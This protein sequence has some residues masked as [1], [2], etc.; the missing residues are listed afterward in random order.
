M[1]LKEEHE[2]ISPIRF[3][4]LN[5]AMDSL[6]IKLIY[7]QDV[8]NESKLLENKYGELV[9]ENLLIKDELRAC[10]RERDEL[11]EQMTST[12][13]FQLL[14]KNYE[15]LV[16]ENLLIR[17]KLN[18]YQQ[19]F[20]GRK[21]QVTIIGEDE[22]TESSLGSGSVALDHQQTNDNLL[23]CH[24]KIIALASGGS[25]S[26]PQSEASGGLM[27]AEGIFSRMSPKTVAGPGLTLNEETDGLD[28]KYHGDQGERNFR[29]YFQHRSVSIERKVNFS[30][31]E[32]FGI[33][34]MVRFQE[35]EPLFRMDGYAHVEAVQLFYSNIHHI[36]RSTFSFKTKLYT[37]V[38][39]VTPNTIA[40]LLGI[41]RPKNP[42]RYPPNKTDLEKVDIQELF[43]LNFN[44][45]LR[46]D[47]CP[48][49]NVLACIFVHNLLPRVG[50]LTRISRNVAYLL[51]CM[52]DSKRIDLAKL[53]WCKMVEVFDSRASKS[54]PVLPYGLLITKMA[55]DHEIELPDGHIKER[56][57]I[58]QRTI[59]CMGLE[60]ALATGFSK[61]R[62][63]KGEKIK[64]CDMKPTT[65]KEIF[66]KL[67]YDE[68]DDD[69]EGSNYE[70]DINTIQ[71]KRTF[72][73]YGSSDD[74][75]EHLLMQMR[76]KIAKLV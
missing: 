8:K 25:P 66:D 7:N 11:R 70:E 46:T 74:E 64:R 71:R 37:K 17:D 61:R 40:A 49:Y 15:E 10:Q 6:S 24:E 75:I 54:K 13:E 14:K 30:S 53:F 72:E 52:H 57:E 1:K 41:T 34:E 29:L 63:K 48:K 59:K 65:Q 51:R 2:T 32:E 68:E 44:T 76:Q 23:N 12:K 22:N 31:F 27:E 4:G 26:L 9:L 36:E 62:P 55:M 28:L 18:V 45:Y 42:A 50:T 35:W 20:K 21:E 39:E 60:E 3:E 73:D 33:L 19:M 47:L 16:F 67:R 43:T 5:P 56:L 58:N 38:F 69:H